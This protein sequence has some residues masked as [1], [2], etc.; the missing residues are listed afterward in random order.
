MREQFIKLTKNALWL[1][2]VL[3]IIRCFFSRNSLIND[4]SFYDVFGYIGEAVGLTVVIITLYERLFWRY[5]PFES[6][7]VLKKRYKG[8]LRSTHDGLERE[9][10]L[11]IKQTLLTISTV[12]QTHES[13][14]KSIT[15]SI[16]SIL[17][18]KQ[19][20]YCFLNTPNASVR[21]R[22]DI[23]YGTAMLCVENV[24]NLSGQYYTDRK[25]TGDIEFIPY[26]SKTQLL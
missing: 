14:S 5:N 19:L 7:P 8:V 10:T 16:E 12:L 22:S 25:T 4:F 6:T 23:H 3:I 1:G 13:K 9:A 18:E 2:T 15:A 17:G 21:D 26:E 11:E 20:T 24:N